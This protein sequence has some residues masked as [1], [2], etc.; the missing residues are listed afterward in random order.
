MGGGE[1]VALILFAALAFG[2]MLLKEKRLADPNDST[3]ISVEQMS[4]SHQLPKGP[5]AAALLRQSGNLY[6]EL[7]GFSSADD[8]L[9]EIKK[10]FRR[11]GID[12]VAVMKNT[13]EKYQVLRLH[14]SHGGK[15]EGKKLGG[16]VIISS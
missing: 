4:A 2:L 13:P 5:V 12:S 1:I 8:A 6:R 9:I 7:G 15:A 10:A 14:H 11:A 16:A 3:M